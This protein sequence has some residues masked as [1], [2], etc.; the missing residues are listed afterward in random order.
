ME[1]DIYYCLLKYLGSTTTICFNT[2]RI[3]CKFIF[4]LIYNNGYTVD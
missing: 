4:L 3:L 1:N 2:I